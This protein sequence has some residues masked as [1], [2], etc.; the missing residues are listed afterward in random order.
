MKKTII[1]MTA[2][3]T[4]ASCGDSG[5]IGGSGSSVFNEVYEKLKESAPEFSAKKS[6]GVLSNDKVALTNWNNATM[7][8]QGLGSESYN[9]K[10]LAGDLIDESVEQSIFERAR[11]PFL[12][13]CC[14]EILANK[15]GDLFT[16]G[17]QTVTFTSEVVGVCGSASDFTGMIGQDITIVVSNLADTTNYDQKIFFDHTTN[18]IFSDSDQWI[19]V[20]NSAAQ[21]N[22]MHIED[23]SAPDFDGSDL[24][25]SSISFDKATESG[26][27][28]SASKYSANDVKLYRIFMDSANDDA[29]IYAHLFNPSG[30]KSVSL[31]MASTFD[32]QTEVG[33]SMSWAS[34]S[35]PYNTNLTNGNACVST[36]TGGII[37]DDSASCAGK[38]VLNVS[39][40]SAIETA[41]QSLVG[42]TI[43]NAA[44][45]DG[46]ADN[47]PSFNAT[48]ILSA[49]LGL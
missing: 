31:N 22:F 49:G 32:N 7:T 11:M 2:L 28:Q 27:Y 30:T 17:T 26:F 36:S 4:L 25:V 24:S 38:T 47:L 10:Q 40:A 34:Q 48:T 15:T 23:S 45:S 44:I 42:L 9:P 6:Y 29:R 39:G 41:V 35:A 37:T 16:T 20:R 19:Y 12:I 43:R 18:P 3:L 1:T 21:L 33:V 8:L 46:L 14:L 5:G 13:S